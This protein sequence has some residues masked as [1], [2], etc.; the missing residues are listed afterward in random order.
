[1]NY[2]R[3]MDPLIIPLCDEINRLNNTRTRY[4]CQGHD[5]GLS[6]PYVM[7]LSRSINEVNLLLEAF[8]PMR[9]ELK[10]V[11]KDKIGDWDN[12]SWDVDLGYEDIEMP[13]LL[14]P[15]DRNLLRVS[16]IKTHSYGSEAEKLKGFQ[17]KIDRIRALRDYYGI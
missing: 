13:E 9:Q 14:K 7:I 10:P 2:P 3:D 16:F 6:R 15:Q 11:H 8:V 12:D 1:M 17:H 4:S 5:D